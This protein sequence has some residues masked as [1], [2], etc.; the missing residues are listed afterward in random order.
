MTR[1]Y[2]ATRQSWTSLLVLAGH[3]YAI[4]KYMLLLVTWTA[5]GDN[6]W[7]SII[8]DLN[9]V[10]RRTDSH[11]NIYQMYS[12]PNWQFITLCDQL[13]KR[14]IFCVCVPLIIVSYLF[15]LFYC[16]LFDVSRTW[17]EIQSISNPIPKCRESTV[18]GYWNAQP[19]SEMSLQ[20]EVPVH[21]GNEKRT[22]L[23]KILH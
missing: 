16:H 18:P 9:K 1:G 14:N 12:I 21:I 22:L 10:Y 20:A 17:A 3:G 2:W 11:W 6:W 8:V 5:A 13:G 23:E 4:F 7:K 19:T 15:L